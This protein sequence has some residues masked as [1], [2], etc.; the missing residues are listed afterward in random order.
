MF[1]PVSCNLTN[2]RMPNGRTNS[3]PNDDAESRQAVTD[4]QIKNNGH[5]AVSFFLFHLFI[6]MVQEFSAS[7]CTKVSHNI[8]KPLYDNI[9]FH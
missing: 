2:I 8:T 3:W 9:I 6:L 4:S 5:T 7:N 1:G